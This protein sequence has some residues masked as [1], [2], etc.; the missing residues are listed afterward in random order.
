[1]SESNQEL[2][3]LLDRAGVIKERYQQVNKDNEFNI[4]SILRNEGEEVGL[5]SRFIYELLNP[6]GVHYKV[7]IFL[8]K[9]LEYI[10]NANDNIHENYLENVKVKREHSHA[11]VLTPA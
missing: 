3:I 9:F 8:S 11:S 5:H 1:M 4:F 2:Q 6:E 10:D 7:D